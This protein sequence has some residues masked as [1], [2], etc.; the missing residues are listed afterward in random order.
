MDYKYSYQVLRASIKNS[1]DS[2]KYEIKLNANVTNLPYEDGEEAIDVLL[3]HINSYLEINQ[4][5]IE[6][7][8][9]ENIHPSFFTIRVNALIETKE[10]V[11]ENLNS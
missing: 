5:I 7:D 6:F 1:Q 11:S 8:T 2:D 3:S 9:N 10:K 4:R